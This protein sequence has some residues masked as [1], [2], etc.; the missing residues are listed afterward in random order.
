MDANMTKLDLEWVQN[1]RMKKLNLFINK[2][3]PRKQSILAYDNAKHIMRLAKAQI[4]QGQK[5]VIAHNGERNH[6]E[7]L[8]RLLGVNKNI[9][10]INSETIDDLDD[11]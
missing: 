3:V 8:R 2:A 11:R 7:P 10:V 5:V 6:H 4:A 1:L 9:L